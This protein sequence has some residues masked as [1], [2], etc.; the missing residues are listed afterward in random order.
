MEEENPEKE[1]SEQPEDDREEGTEK[2]GGSTTTFRLDGA[3]YTIGE[4]TKKFHLTSRLRLKE[5]RN[6]NVY[7]QA[8]I[9]DRI[10]TR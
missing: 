1:V 7:L 6:H 9:F 8:R 5:K 2:C 10:Q 3:T 4:C